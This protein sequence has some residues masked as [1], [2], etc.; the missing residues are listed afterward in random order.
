MERV[1]KSVTDRQRTWSII[2]KNGK[3][4]FRGNLS[5]CD[6]YYS[7]C[8]KIRFPYEEVAEL[9][10]EYQFIKYDRQHTVYWSED[11]ACFHLRTS[12][13]DDDIWVRR[14]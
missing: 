2:I 1:Y 5:R 10:S 12:R 9:Y 13:Y 8:E 14:R 6:C 11:C 3:Y 7:G 4:H